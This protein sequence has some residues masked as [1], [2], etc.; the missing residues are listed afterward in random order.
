MTKIK[1]RY[2]ADFET[3]LTN[4]NNESRVYLW[5]IA[6]NEYRTNYGNSLD[7]FMLY[8]SELKNARIYFH[9]LGGWDFNFIHYYL[10]E[11]EIDYFI[12]E[13][14]GKIYSV[15]INFIIEG[16]K[17]RPITNTVELFDSLNF[18]P[19]TLR[20]IGES[21]NEKYFKTSIDYDTPYEHNATQEEI[22]YCINDVY[23]LVE[24]MEKFYELLVD[25][26]EKNNWTKAKSKIY[27]KP[28]IS[29]IAFEC[30]KNSSSYDSNCKNKDY[31]DSFI[32]KAYYGGFVYSNSELLKENNY[33][34]KWNME[35]NNS[36]YPYQYSDMNLPIGNAYWCDSEEELKNYDFYVIEVNIKFELKRGYVAIIPGAK[37]FQCIQNEYLSSSE[38]EFLNI[39]VSNLD[40]ERIKKYY[41]VE[42][43]FVRG[44]GF[45]TSKG[46]YKQYANTLIEI[47]K[48][49]KG[50]RRQV[51]KLLLNTPYGK[52]AL[53]PIT[54]EIKYS[55][56]DGKIVKELLGKTLDEDGYNYLPQAVAICAGGRKTLFDR[57]EEIDW[58]YIAYTDTDSNKN[59]SP[60]FSQLEHNEGDL[61]KWKD[62]GHPTIFKT[63]AP[64]KYIYYIEYDNEKNPLDKP[65]LSVTCAGFNLN[66]LIEELALQ[67]GLT[68]ETIDEITYEEKGINR[69]KMR[70]KIYCNKDIARKM[71]EKFSYGLIVSCNQKKKVKNGVILQKLDKEIKN[72]KGK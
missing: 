24:A 31:D 28:T 71:V 62:E 46:F 6:D 32:R 20:E 26:C 72:K 56:E 50:A 30:F 60:K 42:Y 64:K 51:A 21:F 44:C 4:E 10:I 39:T 65:Y 66:D 12:C 55:I 11:K 19:F 38:G 59:N 61:G 3:T 17:R 41:D 40:F 16:P 48:T 43:Y 52:L 69:V 14:N 13:K 15:K 27:K 34:G 70:G 2:Y 45:H 7:D 23:V 35:D 37:T 5:A 18:L 33:E 67:A 49:S 63:I 53:N 47:K 54:E 58:K 1:N 25:I 8:I 29:G 22:D 36:M 57:C 68:K 9:N